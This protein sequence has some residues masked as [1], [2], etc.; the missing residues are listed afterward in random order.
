MALM[1]FGWRLQDMAYYLAW[2]AGVLV[3]RPAICKMNSYKAHL[4][5]I[6]F[7]M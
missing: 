1:T 3:M 2:R 4:V 7:M 5:L 6:S